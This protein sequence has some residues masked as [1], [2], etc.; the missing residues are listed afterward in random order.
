MK[1]AKADVI[2]SRLFQDHYLRND[3]KDIGRI[4]NF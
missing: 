4:L 1:R 2:L 3:I